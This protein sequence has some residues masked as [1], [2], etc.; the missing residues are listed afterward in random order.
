METSISQPI[1]TAVVATLNEEKHI[2][3][4]LQCLLDQRGL[5]G[6]LEILVFDGGSDDRTVEIVRSFPEFGTRIRL[7]ENAQRYQAFAYN[8]G[9]RAARG[10]FV[11][12]VVAHADFAEDY[13]AEAIA[14]LQRMDA[15]N[16]GGMQRAVGNGSLTQAIAFAMSSPFGVGDAKYRYVDSERYTDSVFLGVARRE[17]LLAI[18]GFNED[19]P[20]DED[21]DLNLRLRMAGY[22]V[23][24]SPK[25]RCN[26]HVR[27]T[28]A[29][30]AKQMFRY[31]F[32]R[33]KN[34][35]HFGNLIPLRVLAPP[36]LVL[37][38]L[39]S[40]L[41]PAPLCWATAAAY[42]L[43]LGGATAA[44]ARRIDVLA[45]LVPPVLSTMHISYGLGWLA[46]LLTFKQTGPRTLQGALAPE[47][48]L[49]PY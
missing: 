5:S 2:A 21:T 10:A 23:A 32:W 47:Y 44:A 9:I 12:F 6:D 42:A 39:L 7:F 24:T 1:A 26:Y 15:A 27:P 41:L 33:R 3:R 29:A 20:F 16:A 49:Q 14:L 13:L 30:L 18:G 25:L 4:C 31:G 37:G 46:G 35:T 11:W 28:F 17:C 45:F 36:A 38:L 8:R 22:K 43:F 34:Q 48:D 40:P 19:I